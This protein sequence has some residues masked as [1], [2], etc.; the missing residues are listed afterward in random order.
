MACRG[1]K[2]PTKPVPGDCGYNLHAHQV[3]LSHPLSNEVNDKL[4][5]LTESR[6][7]TMSNIHFIKNIHVPVKATSMF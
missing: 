7:K 6:L 3:I 1:F 5:L 2:R 4:H